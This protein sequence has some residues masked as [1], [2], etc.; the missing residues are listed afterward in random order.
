MTPSF[1][2]QKGADAIFVGSLDSNEKHFVVEADAN[3]AYAAP[4]YLVFYRNKTLLAQ[5]FDL[6]RFALT[7]EPSTVLTED[8]TSCRLN[9]SSLGSLIAAYLLLRPAA[10]PIFRNPY[11][12]TAEERR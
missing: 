3:A 10:L 1:S 7:G 2:G 6:S 8:R 4:G 5:P 9:G 12:S 11:G